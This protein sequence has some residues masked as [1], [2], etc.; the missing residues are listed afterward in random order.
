MVDEGTGSLSAIDVSDAL[1][2]IGA[3]YDVEVGADVTMFTLTTL[4]RLAGRGA[5]LLSDML[6]APSMR[7]ADFDRVRQL[8][9]D[10]LKQLKDVAPAVAERAFLRLLYP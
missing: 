8:R 4:A 3:E 5:G 1:A 9:L 6:T 10:R 2:R 7:Q